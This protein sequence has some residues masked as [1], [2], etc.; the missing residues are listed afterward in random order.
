MHKKAF[1][2]PSPAWGAY[3]TP[4]DFL[5]GFKEAASQQGRDKRWEERKTHPPLP[6]I[7]GSVTASKAWNG[8]LNSLRNIQTVDVFKTARKMFLFTLN[9]H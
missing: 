9:T 8:L 6:S 2:E 1:G 4:A 5:H 7:P 3:S